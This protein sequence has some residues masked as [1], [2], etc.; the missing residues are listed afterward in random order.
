[1]GG[2]CVAQHL[3]FLKYDSAVFFSFFYL[4]FT[5]GHWLEV[6]NQGKAGVMGEEDEGGRKCW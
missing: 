6:E 4:W 2:N 1:M 3:F 5:G